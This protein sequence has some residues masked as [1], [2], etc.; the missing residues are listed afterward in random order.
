MRWYFAG[1]LPLLCLVVLVNACPVGLDIA[2]GDK[3]V[4]STNTLAR[5][6]RIGGD[7]GTA[8]TPKKITDLFLLHDGPGGCVTKKSTFDDWLAEVILLHNA[9]TEAY[10]TRKENLPLMVMW[11]TWFGVQIDHHTRDVDLKDEDNVKLWKAIGGTYFHPCA[12]CT[13]HGVLSDD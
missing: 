12:P 2:H 4:N 1:L 11:Y 3:E 13:S 7:G 8:T 6:V 9:I 5:R 10:A